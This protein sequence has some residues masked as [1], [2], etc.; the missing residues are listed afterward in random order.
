MHPTEEYQIGRFI[1]VSEDV[2][3]LFQRLNLV[4]FRC[5]EMSSNSILLPL[6]LSKSRR[7]HYPPC[8]AKRTCEIFPTRD[9]L[10]RYEEALRLEEEMDRILSQPLEGGEKPITRSIQ[11]KSLHDALHGK[12]QQLCNEIKDIPMRHPALE[13]FEEGKDSSSRVFCVLKTVTSLNIRSR[14]NQNHV[15]RRRCSR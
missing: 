5:T 10:L 6:I 3:E 13:R 1:R 15:Q 7:R 2:F 11:A 4:Y 14:I 9:A 8:A 12:W